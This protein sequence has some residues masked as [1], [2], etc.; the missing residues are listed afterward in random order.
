MAAATFGLMVALLLSVLLGNL[1][2][3]LP[4]Y[5]W[6]WSVLATALLAAFFVPFAVRHA[7]A[8][9]P[10]ALPPAR[11]PSGARFS[12]PTSSSTGA[13]STSPAPASWRAT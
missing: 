2:R 4:F 13:S 6:V 5:T 3:S 11:R 7:G 10:L 12:T 8:F 9:A 1:L